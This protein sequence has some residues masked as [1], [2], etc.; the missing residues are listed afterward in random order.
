MDVYL[1][2]AVIGGGLGDIEEVLA[3]GRRLSRAGFPIFFYRRPGRALLPA[4]DGPWEWPPHRTVR[5][6]RPTARVAL[7]VTPAWGVSAA[8]RRSG[9]LGRPGSG[10]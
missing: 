1:L 4:V 7:T 6:L 3:A 10:T 8:P 2:P 5:R 9:A